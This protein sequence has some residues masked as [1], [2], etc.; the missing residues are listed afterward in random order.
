MATSP[1][2]AVAAICPESAIRVRV[3][4]AI[5]VVIMG[6]LSVTVVQCLCRPVAEQGTRCEDAVR[7]EESAQTTREKVWV[8]HRVLVT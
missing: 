3:V 8:T 4:N 1:R 6:G 7:I 5:A 2:G